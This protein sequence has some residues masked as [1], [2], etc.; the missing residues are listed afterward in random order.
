MIKSPRNMEENSRE[1]IFMTS[2]ILFFYFFVLLLGYIQWYWNGS[3]PGGCSEEHGYLWHLE[4]LHLT[5]TYPF[6][7]SPCSEE[8]GVRIDTGSS[9]WNISKVNSQ[10]YFDLGESARVFLC[11]IM[12]IL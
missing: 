7:S 11:K 4:H 9:Q 3:C 1:V 6:G 5:L 12:F 2:Q 8:R 10:L